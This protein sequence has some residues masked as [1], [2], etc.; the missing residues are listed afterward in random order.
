MT[1]EKNN[2]GKFESL[3]IFSNFRLTKKDNKKL[4]CQKIGVLQLLQ[5]P[6]KKINRGGKNLQHDR[7]DKKLNLESRK[8]K[9][10]QINKM[11]AV[12]MLLKIAIFSI[13]RSLLMS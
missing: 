9:T 10:T 2:F 7:S 1:Q 4:W 5:P 13:T 11:G 12:C 8:I 6:N 3:Y